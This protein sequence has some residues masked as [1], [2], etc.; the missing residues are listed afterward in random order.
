[1]TILTFHFG[2]VIARRGSVS[3][4]AGHPRRAAGRVFRHLCP[5][6]RLMVKSREPRFSIDFYCRISGSSEGKGER[7]SSGGDGWC[8]PRLQYVLFLYTG[9][10]VGVTLSPAELHYPATHSKK[11]VWPCA[12]LQR[13][14]QKSNTEKHSV[15]SSVIYM[16]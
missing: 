16:S 12:Q 6:C 9:V 10:A 4:Q 15:W 1:M 7:D 8:E 2:C 11:N 3:H 5:R 14:P 13:T